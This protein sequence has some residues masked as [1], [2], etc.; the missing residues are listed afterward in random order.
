MT[1]I[2]LSELDF[3][4]IRTSLVDYLKKQ[5]T[6]RDLNFEGSAINFLLDLL[7]YN[8]L[9]YAHYANMIAGEAFLDSAQL[10]KTIVSLVK[11]LGYVVPT[12]T[13]A[14]GRIQL[15]NVSAASPLLPYTVSV[16]GTTPEGVQYP[17]W[18]IDSINVT[19]GTSDNFSV[20]QGNY[21]SL[22]YGGNGFEFPDQQILISDLSMDIRTLRVSVKLAAQSTYSV[23]QRYDLYS[24][25]FVT[26][27][28]EIYTIERTSSGFVISFG[29]SLGKKL[30]AGDKVKIEYLSSS[31]TLA[32]N[33]SSFRASI[34]PSGSSVFNV[35][36]ATG[37]LD[38]PE[39]DEVRKNAP[40][41]FS[42]QQRLVT[43][44]DYLSYLSELGINGAKVWGGET[45]NPPVYG[46]VFYSYSDSFGASQTN[47][48]LN[49]LRNRSVVTVVPE[50]ITPITT[51][52]LF[53]LSLRYDSTVTTHTDGNTE[54]I[55]TTIFDQYPTD[56]FDLTFS[57]E[58]VKAAV[59]QQVGYY[60]NETDWYIKIRQSFI[61]SS[62][63][64]TLNFKTEINR[65]NGD[66]EFDVGLGLV[67]DPFS[68]PLF[69]G[70]QVFIQD[71]P[72]EFINSSNPPKIGNLELYEKEASGVVNSLN[73]KVGKI[74][75]GTG[76]V[77]IN[78]N[79]ASGIVTVIG[80]PLNQDVYTGT[81][82]IYVKPEV[83]L[84]KVVAY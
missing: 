13:S 30:V 4:K 48:I 3:D 58:V 2:N 53:A 74:D 27:D 26:A 70:K 29:G 66:G 81:D 16:T 43:A 57:K 41:S 20:Y 51:T 5:E 19:Q 47:A 84:E 1:Q 17:F 24:G 69:P 28:T 21:T 37:G 7:A 44:D 12:K 72:I 6:V 67:S 23:W 71:V 80:T 60:L 9:F 76:I 31:G 82:E 8:T 61:G 14:I 38:S 75:Y 15:R 25:M 18:N 22:S 36:P 64:V 62:S 65:I 11:P 35:L 33:C 59:Q 68:S 77:N 54:A 34:V 42:A 79:I 78:E 32:N 52:V 40:L 10:E 49:K 55:K 56:T 83:G 46:R 39:L 45:N 50:F 63:A 73:Y